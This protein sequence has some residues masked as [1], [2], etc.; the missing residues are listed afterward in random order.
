[1]IQNMSK[2]RKASTD[3]KRLEAGC[4]G[5]ATVLEMVE[6]VARLIAGAEI[7]Q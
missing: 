6:D 1:M 4:A 3:I 7:C 2:P 5:A